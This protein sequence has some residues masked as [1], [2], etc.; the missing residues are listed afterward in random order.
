MIS[1]TYLCYL[2]FYTKLWFV[3]QRKITSIMAD[4]HLC[5]YCHCHC[6]RHWKCIGGETVHLD[7]LEVC[8]T[9]Q[10]DTSVYRKETIGD[11]CQANGVSK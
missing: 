9:V 8:P 4:R 6:G 1:R 7:F 5:T 11:C 3:L 10:V 2:F